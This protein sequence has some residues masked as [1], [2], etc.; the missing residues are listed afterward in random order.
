MPPSGAVVVAFDA[1]KGSLTALEACQAAARGVR[2]AV[3]RA[4]VAA[5]SGSGS[6]RRSSLPFAVSGSRSSRT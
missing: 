2:G 4:S 1:F 6:A 3:G 5:G